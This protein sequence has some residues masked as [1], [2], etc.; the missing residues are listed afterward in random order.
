MLLLRCVPTRYKGVRTNTSDQ[1]SL[2]LS[3]I[4]FTDC[5][6]KEETFHG[7][8]DINNPALSVCL[9]PATVSHPPRGPAEAW[10]DLP[11]PLTELAS[12][13]HLIN[14]NTQ[15]DLARTHHPG[16]YVINVCFK[17]GLKKIMV[18]VS[19]NSHVIRKTY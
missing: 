11:L 6:L 13:H 10:G 7:H 3:F 2:S 5:S 4:L 14:D 19:Q 17:S 16:Q 18:L 12:G 1:L 15:L 8:S 9:S